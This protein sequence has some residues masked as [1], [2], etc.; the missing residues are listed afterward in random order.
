M[1]LKYT[2]ESLDGIDE[3]MRGLYSEKDGKFV[4]SVDGL[5]EQED[6]TGLKTAL[7][8]ERAN[9]K[10]FGK[11]IKRWEGLGKSPE[12]ISELLENLAENERKKAEEDGDFDK[13]LSQHKTKWEKEKADLAG[14]LEASRASE[15]KAIID[16][17]LKSSLVTAGATG[18]G[19]DL[20]PVILS[21]R[22]K[23]ETDGGERVIRILAEDGETPLA[24]SSKDGTAT[25]ED[26]AKW[27]VEK[28]PSLFKGEG[29]GGGG[30]QPD[31]K[32]G[33][34]GITK[35]SDFKTETARAA[36]VTEFGMTAYKALPD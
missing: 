8:R 1:S 19:M 3:A 17:S 24:G 15:R 5:P 2:V 30:K 6:N 20:L 32:A 26:L 22:I 34:S 14:E 13:L 16:N 11:Q 29:R 36:F 25:F 21:Q 7:E 18:E 12:E 27:A 28:Y 31:T 10:Q 4:L 9:A 33:R 35:K 23:F